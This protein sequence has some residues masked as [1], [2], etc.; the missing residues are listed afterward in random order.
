MKPYLP[1]KRLL[2][3]FFSGM[4]ILALSPLLVPVMIVLLCTGEHYIFYGQT[5][6]G[7]RNARFK[8][9]KFATM[10][11]DSPN[12]EGGLHT[13]KGDPRVLPFGRFLRKTKINELPQLF[14]IF[15]GDMSIVGPRPLVDKTFDPYPPEVKARIYS[16]RPGLTGIGSIVFR[17]EETLITNSKLPPDECYAKEIAPY[18]GALEMWYLDHVGLWTDCLLV[19]LTAWVVVFPESDLVFKVFRDLPKRAPASGDAP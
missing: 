3:I 5:R 11:L 10:L 17:D 8:I 19:F 13:T 18:K 7:Y 1:L 14:N 16:V 9:W 15:V 4:A 6:I 12:M 2:D